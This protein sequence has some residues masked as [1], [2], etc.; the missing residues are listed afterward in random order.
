MSRLNLSARAT[1]GLTVVALL[2]LPVSPTYA[3][4]HLDG[5]KTSADQSADLSDVFAFVSPSDPS[6]VVLVLDVHPLAFK[7]TQFSDAVDYK[8]RIRPVDSSTM[9][10]STDASQE[11]SVVCSFAANG[12]T[13]PNQQATC[14]L[15][16]HGAPETVTFQTRGPGFMA[17]GTGQTGTSKVFAGV[18]SD[19]YATDTARVGAYYKLQPAPTA[20][21]KNALK[22]FN[23][24]SI[25][26]E[27]D[28][29]RLPSPLLAVTAQTVRR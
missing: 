21:T 3:S 5:V 29:S 20:P 14:V 19:P 6:R 24:L 27:V 13:A 9:T 26:V 12:L 8:F 4:D 7:G 25:V 10:A 2:S 22:G 11:E 16:L 17:G 28:A 18:R 23:V 1:L 15:T